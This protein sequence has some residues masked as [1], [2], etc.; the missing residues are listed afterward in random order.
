MDM[1]LLDGSSL[2]EKIGSLYAIIGALGNFYNVFTQ[3]PNHCLTS[4]ESNFLWEENIEG[5]NGKLFV[6]FKSVYKKL[7][8]H[9]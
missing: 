7:V 4:L 3:V 5:L 8:L 6:S 2:I 9:H 1:K